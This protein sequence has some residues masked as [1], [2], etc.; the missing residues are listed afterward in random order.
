[1]DKNDQ[2][3]YDSIVHARVPGKNDDLKTRLIYQDKLA[4]MMDRFKVLAAGTSLRDEIAMRAMVEMQKK[5]H[6]P[7]PCTQIAKEA[8]DLADAFLEARKG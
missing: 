2:E 7:T 4:N 8:Y 1:M 6:L 5:Y 3:I